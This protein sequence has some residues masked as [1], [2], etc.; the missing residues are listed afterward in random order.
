M[1]RRPGALALV[2]ASLTAVPVLCDPTI[3]SWSQVAVKAIVDNKLH[4]N[5][6]APRADSLEMRRGILP[7]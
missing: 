5:V 1:P 7:T 6:S 4:T 3:T 2:V